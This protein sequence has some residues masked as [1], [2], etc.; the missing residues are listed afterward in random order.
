MEKEKKQ[1]LEA[2]MFCLHR[3]NLT[4]RKTDKLDLA[5]LLAPLIDVLQNFPF[6]KLVKSL[7]KFNYQLRYDPD[8]SGGY[9]NGQ[10]WVS[11]YHKETER[12]ALVKFAYIIEFLMENRTESTGEEWIAPV[13]R[14]SKIYDCRTF[15]WRKN[16]KDF[17][18][19]RVNNPASLR[20]GAVAPMISKS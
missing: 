10:I 2:V 18:K 12:K 6:R 4:R 13:V 9:T 1:L 7:K 11:F 20:G 19:F 16:E 5:Y 3:E 8:R 14:I 17:E 15:P